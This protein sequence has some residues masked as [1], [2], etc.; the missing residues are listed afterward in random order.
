MTS[1]RKC[2]KSICSGAS[3]ASQ[4]SD[5]TEAAVPTWGGGEEEY[6]EVERRLAALRPAKSSVDVFMEDEKRPL[7][8][9]LTK[10]AAE[11][12]ARK[13]AAPKGYNASPVDR[14]C[15]TKFDFLL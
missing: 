8:R 14:S 3:T 6:L 2:E 10:R 11:S 1:T 15:P 7:W 9:E 5:P 13:P 12:A 4:V